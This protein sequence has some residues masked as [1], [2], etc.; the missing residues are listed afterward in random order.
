MATYLVDQGIPPKIHHEG[1][2]RNGKAPDA[3][4]MSAVAKGTN[5]IAAKRKKCIYTYGRDLNSLVAG[6]AADRTFGVGYN[7]NGYNTSR[8]EFQVGFI[9]VAQ[10][11]LTD[12]R[13]KIVVTRESDSSTQTLYFYS[14]QFA[15]GHSV[16][17][18]EKITWLRQGVAVNANEAYS[19]EVVEENYARCVAVCAFEVGSNPVNDTHT[20]IVT[21]G[22]GTVGA[23][24]LDDDQQDMVEAQTNLW[25]R[26]GGVLAWY[27]YDTTPWAM[28]STSYTNLVDRTNTTYGVTTPGASIDL[29]Y[30]AVKSSA[31]VPVRLAVLA[32]RT[33]GT[34]STADNRARFTDGT[35]LI[36]LTG[37]GGTKQWY[38]VDGTLPIGSGVTKYDFEVRTSGDTVKFYGVTV[39]SYE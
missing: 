4:Y 26:N 23:P 33:S 8:M 14:L 6:Q 28:T 22:V 1:F 21:Q 31:T 36:E 18:P 39:L 9:R 5:H 38:T 27:S 2:V 25:K 16:D 17:S 11:S 35:N 10:A 24:I 37:I 19:F 20:G 7:W 29:R 15:T 32:E 34:G 3:A 30:S 13:V 12:C